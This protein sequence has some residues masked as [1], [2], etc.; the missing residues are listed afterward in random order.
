LASGQLTGLI[1]VSEPLPSPSAQETEEGTSPM[2]EISTVPHFGLTPVNYSLKYQQLN[3]SRH[4]AFNEN[5]E[6]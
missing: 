4:E 5:S 6:Y 3:L 1:H 2:Q